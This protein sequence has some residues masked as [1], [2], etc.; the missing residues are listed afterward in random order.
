MPPDTRHARLRAA[1]ARVAV[2]TSVDEA[3]GEIER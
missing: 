3:M 2:V 1:G